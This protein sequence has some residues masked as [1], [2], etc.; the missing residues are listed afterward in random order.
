MRE[1][2]ELKKQQ[3]TEH[4]RKVL[5]EYKKGSPRYKEI[6]RRFQEEVELEDLETKKKKL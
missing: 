1:D 5:A 4:S 2:K 3:L 6:E